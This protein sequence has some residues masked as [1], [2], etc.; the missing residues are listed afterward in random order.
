MKG[1]NVFTIQERDIIEKQLVV[2][3][4]NIV[5][6]EQKKIRHELK[7]MSFYISDFRMHR[8]GFTYSDFVELI[9]KGE[10]IIF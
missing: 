9:E 10:I 7:N 6:S 5:K 3:R 2:L 1:K 4:S 8:S